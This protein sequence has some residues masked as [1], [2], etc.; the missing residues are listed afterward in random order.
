MNRRDELLKVA[1]FDLEKTVDALSSED[2]RKLCKEFEA[3]AERAA[4]Y[5]RYLDERHGYGCGDQ[6]HAKAVKAMNKAGK[7]VHMKVFGYN[8]FHELTI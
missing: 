7:M 4:M 2:R 1:P 6:G 8:A 5:A 3:L